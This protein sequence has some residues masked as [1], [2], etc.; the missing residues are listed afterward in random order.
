[1][2]ALRNFTYFI[3]PVLLKRKFVTTLVICGCGLES[4]SLLCIHSIFA[5]ASNEVG[6]GLSE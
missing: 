3:L 1:M 6:Y 2:R 4:C 5:A